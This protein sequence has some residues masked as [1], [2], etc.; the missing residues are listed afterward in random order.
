VVCAVDV[1]IESR[2]LVFKRISD[3]ALGGEVITFIRAH[4]VENS[5]EAGEAFKR[6]GVEMKPVLD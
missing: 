2:E 3:E 4:S 1:G 6:C 5:I